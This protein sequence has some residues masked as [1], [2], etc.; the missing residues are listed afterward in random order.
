MNKMI[1]RLISLSLLLSIAF[2]EIYP[3]PPDIPEIQ[4]MYDHEKITIT[5]DR[6]AESSIDPLTGYSDFEGYRI[7]KSTDGGVTWGK[8][9]NRIYDHDGNQ[10]GWEP[11]AKYD[12][13]EYSDSLHC[14]YKNAYYDSAEG[15]LCYSRGYSPSSIDSVSLADEQ[16]IFNDDSSLVY[17]PRY[18]RNVDIS[19]YDPFAN[20]INLGEDL[21]ISNTIE[22][23]DVIDGVE[24][25]YAITAYDMGVRTYSIEFIDEVIVDDTTTVVDGVFIADTTWNISNPDKYTGLGGK[26]YPSFESPILFESFT[27]YNANGIC[28]NNEPFTDEDSSDTNGN[29]KCDEVGDWNLRVNPINV[30][31]VQAGYKASNITYPEVDFIIADSSN[32]GNGERLYNIVN[33]YELTKSVMRFEIEAGLDSNSFGNSII[34]SFATLD[35]ALYVFEAISNNNYSPKFTYDVPVEDLDEDSLNAILGLPGANFDIET[36]LVAIP[37]YKLED[38]KLTYVSDPLFELQWTDWFDGIQFRFDNGPNNL[39]GNPLAIVDIKK[40]TYSDTTLSNFINVKMR[41]KNKNDLPLRPMFNYRIDFSSTIL[42]TAYQ[43]TGNG[44]N[45]LPDINTQLPFKVTNMTTGRQVKVQHLDKGTQPAKINYG[46]L[47][48]GGGCIPVCAQSETCIEQECISTTG[49]KNCKWEFDESLVLIDTVYTSNNLEGYDEKIYNLKLG[50][51]WNRYFLLMSRISPSDITQTS[52][53]EM[54]WFP[55]QTF[56]SQDVVIYEGMLYKAMEDISVSNAPDEWFDNDGDDINDN[57][58]QVL[59]PWND[60]DYVI[61]EPYGWY[62]DGDAWVVDMSEIGAR[63]DDSSDDLDDITVVPN[64]YI[65]NSNYFNESPGNSLMRFTHLP[66]KCTISIYTVTGEFVTTI[67]HDDD[68]DGSEW[69]DVRNGK[70]QEVA[71]GL[72]IYTVE[73]PAGEKKIDKFAVVR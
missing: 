47:S 29:G 66:K 65:V 68:F 1:H 42:D 9:W 25:T 69:W 2:S 16:A 61:I 17:L 63:D 11:F 19:G 6:I 55:T 52:W 26:G 21:G 54:I 73:T 67:L 10:V 15:E 22:D 24:Y 64:P 62:K 43:V 34:G 40:I 35:P 48:A 36:G 58:W 20:W 53:L 39:D 50:I 59:Y 51:N 27:D 18:I 23:T 28:D 49:Y 31:T 72:Y 41:Y 14:I 8:S 56:E 37:E 4:A 12:L 33:E 57:P 44:C 7:Y 38:F 46:E 71:P 5:W 13:T 3:T 32:V 30:I 45:A 70:G 60:S